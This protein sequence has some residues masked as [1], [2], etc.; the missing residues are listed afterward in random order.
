MTPRALAL[1]HHCGA[2]AGELHA[3]DC[4]NRAGSDAFDL[5]AAVAVSHSE[6]DSQTGNGPGIGNV[7]TLMLGT[8][9]ECECP[10]C[11]PVNIPLPLQERLLEAF[12]LDEWDFVV[13]AFITR[14]RALIVDMAYERLRDGFPTYRSRMYGW[15]TD[16]RT[17]NALEEVADLVNYLSS[18][19]VE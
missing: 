5:T 10:G 3:P 9:H 6:P 14:H 15:G 8:D 19:E 11:H 18:G 13:A 7:P 16:E 2:R 12:L 17:E 1:C 4:P